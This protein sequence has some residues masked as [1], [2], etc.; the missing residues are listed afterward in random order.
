MS[1][2]KN[3][4]PVKGGRVHK[5]VKVDYFGQV[6]P[7]N[8]GYRVR[9]CERFHNLDGPDSQ[10]PAP[11]FGSFIQIDAPITCGNCLRTYWP[12]GRRRA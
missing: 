3:V 1:E 8:H 10:N 11:W 12:D 9:D 5:V 4:T 6:I 2:L 7:S